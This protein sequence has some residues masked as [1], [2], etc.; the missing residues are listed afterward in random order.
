MPSSGTGS[1]P[2]CGNR[3]ASYR[4]VEA[5]LLEHRLGRRDQPAPRP[6]PHRLKYEVNRAGKTYP[7]DPPFF[8]MA[9]QNPI[10]WRTY[11][12]RKPS[13]TGSCFRSTSATDAGGRA[14]DRLGHRR[15]SSAVSR[16]SRGGHPLDSAARAAGATSQHMVDYAVD[17]VR[18]AQGGIRGEFVRLAHLGRS[19]APRTS[20]WGPK[21]GLDGRF[22][23]Q[24]DIA[25]GYPVLRHRLLQFQRRRRGDRR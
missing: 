10:R 11:R 21:A 13:S 19:R 6:R 24:P 4:F 17:L 12:C 8:V 7:L 1:R 20:F 15:R 9:T 16:S 5:D 23:S 3:A 25:A 2:G 18:T 22:A 14:R